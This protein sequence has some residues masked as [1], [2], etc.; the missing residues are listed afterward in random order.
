MGRFLEQIGARG[1]P[2]RP[3]RVPRQRDFVPRPGGAG[4]RPA[5]GRPRGRNGDAG[6]T[7]L[8]RWSP[9]LHKSGPWL[10]P[11]R[12]SRLPHGRHLRS[13]PRLV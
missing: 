12:L 3:V 4:R 9:A 13:E 8:L 7:G 11:G 10:S 6:G 5:G 1:D 2:G